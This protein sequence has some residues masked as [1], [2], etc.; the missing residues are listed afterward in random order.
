MSQ[1]VLL[2]DEVEEVGTSA[3]QVGRPIKYDIGYG[4]YVDCI[5]VGVFALPIPKD[6]DNPNA[7]N[8]F[9][10]SFHVAI[11]ST[12]ESM[13]SLLYNNI[14]VFKICPVSD[15]NLI[16]KY[17]DIYDLPKIPD[18]VLTPEDFENWD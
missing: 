11:Q 16:L 10:S 3:L 17:N 14:P 7:D 6:I 4:D 9:R 15:D 13:N 5:V 1:Y 18:S 2:K 12:R 8:G